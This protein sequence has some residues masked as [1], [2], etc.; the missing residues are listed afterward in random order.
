MV[1]RKTTR[2]LG[3]NVSVISWMVVNAWNSEIAMPIAMPAS[4]IGALMI[5][6]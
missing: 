4:M 3:T 6:I 5:K 1:A 2:I